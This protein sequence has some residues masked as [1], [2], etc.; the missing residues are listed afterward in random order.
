MLREADLFPNIGRSNPTHVRDLLL[1]DRVY[2]RMT[3]GPI[4]A[5]DLLTAVRGPGVATVDDP[6]EV[7]D[8]ACPPKA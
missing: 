5:H 3:V 2:L 6:D 7:Q 8:A 1:Q 4:T